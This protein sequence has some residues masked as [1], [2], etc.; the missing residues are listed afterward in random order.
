MSPEQLY[1]LNQFIQ[2]YFTK[3][4][5][6][7]VTAVF[8]A[9]SSIITWI[10]NYRRSRKNITIQVNKICHFGNAIV[11]HVT[12]QN[13]SRLPISINDVSAK[14]KGKLYNGFHV[15]QCTINI[16]TITENN[17]TA[18]RECC[19]MSFPINLGSLSGVSGYLFFDTSKEVS[20]TL[21]THLT[22]RVSTNRGNSI[23]MKSALAEWVN[24]Q[25]ML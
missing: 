4:N 2:K 21:S 19:T 6:T 17:V 1:L 8:G 20:E 18:S 24:W 5:L 7:L 10:I 11:A 14:I 3:D 22:F 9:L 23:E 12:I 25:T 15:P 13:E 16:S